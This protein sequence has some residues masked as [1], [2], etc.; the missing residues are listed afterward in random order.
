MNFNSPQGKRESL[1]ISL[2]LVFLS[3]SLYAEGKR[4]SSTCI[5]L[6]AEKEFNRRAG[7]DETLPLLLLLLLLLGQARE[8]T[9]QFVR[10]TTI[11]IPRNQGAL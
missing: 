9:V 1:F 4:S 6:P 11:L 10:G 7:V 8:E 5:S 2:P 3:L